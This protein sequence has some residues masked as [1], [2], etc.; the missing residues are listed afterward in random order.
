MGVLP[1]ILNTISRALG[2]SMDAATRAGGEHIATLPTGEQIW[3]MGEGES[4]WKIWVDDRGDVQSSLYTPQSNYTE[5]LGDQ[6]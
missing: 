3:S 2:H 6:E 5:L 4:Q 1:D